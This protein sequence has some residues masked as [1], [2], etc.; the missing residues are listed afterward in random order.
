MGLS[1]AVASMRKM[2]SASCSGSR[3]MKPPVPPSRHSMFRGRGCWPRARTT[4]TPIPSS[5]MITLPSPRTRVLVVLLFLFITLLPHELP[6]AYNR[7]DRTASLDVVV[8]EAQVNVDDD[9]AHEEPQEEVMPVANAHL[10]AEQRHDPREHPGDERVA[11]AGV[12]REPGEGLRH[13]RQ[14]R[15]EINER[16]Q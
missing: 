10:S 3:R 8:I 12:E 1:S 14:E 9:K 15:E 11:H 13:E 2:R 5:P 4:C 6:S 7:R 16:R